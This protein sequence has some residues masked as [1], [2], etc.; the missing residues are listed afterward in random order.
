MYVWHSFQQIT[1]SHTDMV[2]DRLPNVDR[3]LAKWN[4]VN[5]QV[6]ENSMLVATQ[7]RT[8]DK[9]KTAVTVVINSS[10]K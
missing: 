9:L 10:L 7:F 3:K 4:Q 6:P 8:K 2:T 1:A 5:Q